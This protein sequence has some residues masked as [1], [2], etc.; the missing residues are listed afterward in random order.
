MKKI[1]LIVVLAV[2]SLSLFSQEP[3]SVKSYYG[4]GKIR[5]ILSY[6]DSNKLDGV[7]ITY[8]E[9]GVQTG[10]AYYS[11][12]LKDGTWKIWREDGSLAYEM[13]YKEGQ[14][15]GKWKMYD[16]QGNIEGERDFGGS[17]LF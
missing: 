7:C 6:N 11:N 5:E 2:F 8:S 4:N 16:I 12:G 10:I 15:I 14:R 1:L 17:N 3:K 13:Y 9:S